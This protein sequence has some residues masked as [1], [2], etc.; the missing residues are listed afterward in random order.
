MY[1]LLYIGVH[2]FTH[3]Y[4]FHVTVFVKSNESFVIK[5]KKLIEM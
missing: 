4:T 5:L 2:T 1:I 3:T